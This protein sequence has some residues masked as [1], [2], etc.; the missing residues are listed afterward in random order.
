MLGQQIQATGDSNTGML[1]RYGSSLFHD[2][3]VTTAF[4]ISIFFMSSAMR[5]WCTKDVTVSSYSSKR[6]P[7][8]SHW[9]IAL[10]LLRVWMKTG[11]KDEILSRPVTRDFAA[12]RRQRGHAK[13]KPLM[14]TSCKRDVRRQVKL[15]WAHRYS[16]ILLSLLST[17][18]LGFTESGD[19]RHASLDVLAPWSGQAVG[20]GGEVEV[21][22][23]QICDAV[24]MLCILP[25]EAH[26]CAFSMFSR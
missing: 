21:R 15:R 16:M 12:V 7:C 23:T 11:T 17:I 3:T 24:S 8:G 18:D 13:L 4:I 6:P 19:E 2:D 25:K 14:L 20:L 1:V 9:C 5:K 10:T 22:C 26:A